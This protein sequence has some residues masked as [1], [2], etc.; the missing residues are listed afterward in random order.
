MT[1]NQMLWKHIRVIL[2]YQQATNG[3]TMHCLKALMFG[4]AYIAEKADIAPS[5]IAK[6][7]DQVRDDVRLACELTPLTGEIA[8]A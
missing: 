3:D 6:L 8:E 2:E 7:Q 4:I 1:I 5:M